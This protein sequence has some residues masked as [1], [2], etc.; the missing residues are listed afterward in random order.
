MMRSTVCSNAS[1]SAAGVTAPPSSLAQKRV[2]HRPSGLRVGQARLEDAEQVVDPVVERERVTLEVEEQVSR[3][4]LGKREQSLVRLEPPV[5]PSPVIRPSRRRGGS[6][7]WSG[8]P[9]PH[10]RPGCEPALVT[11]SSAPAFVCSAGA[12]A[13]ATRGRQA[14]GGCRRLAPRRSS[15]AGARGDAGD[16]R[17]VVIRASSPADTPRP[18]DT[19]RNG[20]RAPDRSAAAR[21]LP[22]DRFLERGA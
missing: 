13:A 19:R 3:A 1:F 22:S 10:L 7:S 16:Q 8:C 4:G 11:R 6:N 18:N 15:D 2:E 14:R 12:G 9:G 17:Q 21:V 5:D 20:R